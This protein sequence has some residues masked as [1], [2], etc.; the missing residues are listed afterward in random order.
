MIHGLLS[1]SSFSSLGE[2]DPN[3]VIAVVKKVTE[4]DQKREALLAARPPLSEIL[5]LH[6]FEVCALQRD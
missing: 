3:T 4:A 6:D 1:K 2:I 5:N